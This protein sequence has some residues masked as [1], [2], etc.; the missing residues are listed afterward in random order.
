MEINPIDKVQDFI[1]KLQGYSFEIKKQSDEGYD[2]LEEPEDMCVVIANPTSENS[3]EIQFENEGE[4]TLFFGHTHSHYFNDDYEYNTLCDN[5]V[6]ILNNRLG[7]GSL[8]YGTEDKNW[9][10]STFVTLQQVNQPIQQAFDFTLKHEE[11]SNKLRD[12]GGEARFVF[13]TD[14]LSKTIK[15]DKVN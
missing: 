9:L 12:F 6:D 11:F 4:F 15:I 2:W 8:F 3:L 7:S 14:S 5:V 10:G 13:W 1:D